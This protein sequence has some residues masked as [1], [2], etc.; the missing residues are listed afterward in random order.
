MGEMERMRIL[1]NENRP[2]RFGEEL[3][4]LEFSE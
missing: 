3:K 2:S 1:L 4:F